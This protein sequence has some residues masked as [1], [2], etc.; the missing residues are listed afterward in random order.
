MDETIYA[1]ATVDKKPEC[2]EGVEMFS[3]CVSANIELPKTSEFKG[4]KVIVSFIINIDGSIQDTKVLRDCGYGTGE[5]IKRLLTICNHWIPG[6]I[7]GNKVRV[8]YVM[9]I[10][11][12]AAELEMNT[13]FK[14]EAIDT[15]E[16]YEYK[17]LQKAPEFPGGI[18]MFYRF[19][20]KNY[21]TPQVEKLKGKI[22]VSF[23]IEKDGS[24][25]NGKIIQ[26]I[27]Y[28]TGQEAL[29]VLKTSPLWTP[30]VIDDKPVRVLFSF[31]I[32]IEP[33][34]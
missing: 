13:D 22:F 9:P 8:S 17:A 30:G 26:D 33:G 18:E 4:G 34:R 29:K 31:P 12:P 24:I 15:S 10:T 7:K 25:T 21:I 11:I 3:K 32:N 27:G 1:M 16:V 20:A 6:E 2:E 23:V 28:G 5:E 14:P 19:I